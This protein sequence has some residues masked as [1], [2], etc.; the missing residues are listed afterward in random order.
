MQVPWAFCQPL[1]KHFIRFAGSVKAENGGIAL[2]NPHI[3]VYLPAE[4][5]KF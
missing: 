4:N 3:V 1:S 5:Y 2:S